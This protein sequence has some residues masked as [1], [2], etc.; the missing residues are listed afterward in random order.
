MLS[1]NQ[2]IL[3]LGIPL[4]VA[5]NCAVCVGVTD[6]NFGLTTT[7]LAAIM[8]VPVRVAVC[9][10][11][12]SVSFRVRKPARVPTADGL[13]CTFTLQVAAGARLVPQVLVCEKSPLAITLMMSTEPVPLL[14][15]VIFWTALPPP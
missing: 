12:G 13:N 6:V 15:T 11:V 2:L 14:V 7:A 1:T 10:F 3:V 9:R 5:V 8:P 4:M